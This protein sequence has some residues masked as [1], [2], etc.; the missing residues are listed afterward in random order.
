MLAVSTEYVS[1]YPVATMRVL[2]ALLKAVDLCVSEPEA[3][4]RRTVDGGFARSYDT[5]SRH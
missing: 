4:A 3:V 1:K 5:R 2:R